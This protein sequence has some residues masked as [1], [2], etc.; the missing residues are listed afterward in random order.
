MPPWNDGSLRTLSSLYGA[1]QETLFYDDAPRTAL[2]LALHALDREIDVFARRLRQQLEWVYTDTRTPHFERFQQETLALAGPLLERRRQVCEDMNASRDRLCASFPPEIVSAIF[3]FAVEGIPIDDAI[4]PLSRLSATVVLAS[5][6]RRWRALVLANPR[7]WVSFRLIPLTMDSE[8]DACLDGFDYFLS[9]SGAV[10]L[11]IYLEVNCD[12]GD[13]FHRLVAIVRREAHRVR[14]LHVVFPRYT[15]DDFIALLDFPFPNADVVAI[16]ADDVAGVG[17]QLPSV[18]YLRVKG[19]E[20]F[21]PSFSGVT[22]LDMEGLCLYGIRV[23][24]QTAVGL[25]TLKTT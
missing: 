3:E 24:L 17:F 23:L 14:T 10:G 4:P 21:R 7:L 19:I 9:R 8:S 6:T 13:V 18:S 2:P 11:H 20:G 5:V 25:K 22:F 16:D 12:W 15:P 1:E